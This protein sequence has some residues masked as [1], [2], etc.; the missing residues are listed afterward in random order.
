MPKKPSGADHDQ[1]PLYRLAAWNALAKFQMHGRI[2]SIGVSNF[3]MKHLQDL[4]KRSPI[5]PALNQFQWH[6]KYRSD[7]LKSYCE[8]NQILLQAQSSFGTSS[9]ASLRSYPRIVEIAEKH[10]KSPSQILL[11]W[12]TQNDVLII[13]KASFKNHLE[14]NI[15][16]DFEI[17]VED[18]QI[19]NNFRTRREKFMQE[20]ENGVLQR[21]NYCGRPF[22][23]K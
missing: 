19:L 4:K 12:A 22:R 16:L 18:M 9:D 14:E 20:I 15:N 23:K 21:L 2:R 3:N 10:S 6:P 8:Q 5:V 7:Q 1:E 17:S 11:R 13:P